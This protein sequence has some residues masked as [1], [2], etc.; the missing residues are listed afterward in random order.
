MSRVGYRYLLHLAPR[1]D[2]FLIPRTHGRWSSVGKGT[3][4]LL[5]A[6]GAKSGQ[7]REAPV[8][9]VPE[10][11]GTLLLI[12]S[13]YGRAGHPAWSAN[14]LAHPECTL[15]YEGDE[16]RFRARLLEGVEREAAWARA[17][18]SYAGYEAYKA[19]AAPRVI[20][21]FRLEPVDAGA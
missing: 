15:I 12:G 19:S 18:D 9:P 5:T 7:P 20:R 17:A 2:R 6:T 14:L 1:I 16:R 8:L 10:P 21:V 13:N 3:V 4:G 11:E